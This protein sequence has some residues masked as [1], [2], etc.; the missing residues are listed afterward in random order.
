MYTIDNGI[1]K[2]EI[3]DLACEL[4]SLIM[5]GKEY[6]WQ[7]DK[8]FWGGRAPLL[9]PINGTVKDNK[10]FIGGQECNL[11]NHGFLRHYTFKVLEQNETKIVFIAD[12]N[13]DTLKNFPFKFNVIVTFELDGKTCK[14]SYEVKN[15]DS[16]KMPYFF[17]LHPAFNCHTGTEKFDEYYIEFDKEVEIVRP[18]QPKEG[19]Y[20]DLT[21]VEI[22]GE[23]SKTFNLKH[24][25]FYKHPLIQSNIEFNESSICHKTKGKILD[26][27]F[28]G[29]STFVIWQAKDAPFVCVEPWTGVSGTPPYSENLEDNPK[30]KFLEASKSD[31]Y[32]FDITCI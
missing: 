16:A 8:A 25:H 4:S 22:I 30:C 19:E 32:T 29:F 10:V 21:N 26:I 5:D 23:K 2:A 13:E 20:A 7:G 27:K 11:T 9:F 15:V 6:V 1:I 17:G 14:T 12:A 31:K 28:D 24:E 18:H 3:N